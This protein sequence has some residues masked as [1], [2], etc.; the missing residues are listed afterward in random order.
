MTDVREIIRAA[1]PGA[2]EDFCEYFM[3]ERTPY[4]FGRISAKNLYKWA[5]SF[6]RAGENNVPLCDLCENMATNHKYTCNRCYDALHTVTNI[7]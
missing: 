1:I 6:R 2:T 7:N 4:P 5:S 3:W